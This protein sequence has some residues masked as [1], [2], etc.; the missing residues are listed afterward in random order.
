[1]RG[2]CWTPACLQESSCP[3]PSAFAAPQE[4]WKPAN[5][6]QAWLRSQPIAS[7]CMQVAGLELMDLEEKCHRKSD[8]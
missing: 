4:L 7:A 6:Q 8:F 3:Q 2:H 5:V 1:M